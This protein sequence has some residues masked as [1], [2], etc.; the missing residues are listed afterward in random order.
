MDTV[1]KVNVEKLVT[2]LVDLHE[3]MYHIGGTRIITK[4]HM[5]AEWY[6]GKID[7]LKKSIDCHIGTIKELEDENARLKHQET[8]RQEQWDTLCY[9]LRGFGALFDDSFTEKARR[10]MKE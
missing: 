7:E 3:K 1:D 2:A 4:G 6:D 9:A 5:S 10:W 8:N